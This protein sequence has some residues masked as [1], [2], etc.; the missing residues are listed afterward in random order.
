MPQMSLYIK[1]FYVLISLTEMTVPGWLREFS[2]QSQKEIIQFVKV[3]FQDEKVSSELHSLIT[4]SAGTDGYSALIF[5]AAVLK[6]L[7]NT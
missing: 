5:T 2:W 6:M 4:F 3:F 1:I 7:P